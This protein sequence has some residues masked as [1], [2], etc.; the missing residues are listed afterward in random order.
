MKSRR[1]FGWLDF[2]TYS[3]Y[4]RT[5]FDGQW[6]LRGEMKNCWGISWAPEPHPIYAYAYKRTEWPLCH[7][8]S[9]EHF[10][11]DSAKTTETAREK[12]R[13]STDVA[14]L[15]VKYG[16]QTSR[17]PPNRQR[18]CRCR[19]FATRT[20]VRSESKWQQRS[21][22][23]WNSHRWIRK[24]SMANVQA[25]GSPQSYRV[26]IISIYLLLFGRAMATVYSRKEINKKI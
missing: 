3:T 5:C 20:A 19:V 25:R 7:L 8:K 22:L 16:G 4:K 17:Y 11:K 23:P 26:K 6:I 18:C 13:R 24:S 12:R 10:R 1:K 21:N 9:K 14:A 15:L 2:R